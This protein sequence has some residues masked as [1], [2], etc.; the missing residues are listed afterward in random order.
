MFWAVCG[1]CYTYFT[2]SFIDPH[3]H[4]IHTECNPFSIYTCY[5]HEVWPVLLPHVLVNQLS[6][7][8]SDRTSCKQSD[9]IDWPRHHFISWIRTCFPTSK[10][11]ERLHSDQTI[12]WPKFC[13]WFYLWYLSNDI[14]HVSI[15]SQKC[16][17]HFICC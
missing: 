1:I 13:E 10:Q 7:N 17:S 15:L 4:L 6:Q 14:S 8:E 3:M 12:H 9:G 11:L 2:L 5:L 16:Y